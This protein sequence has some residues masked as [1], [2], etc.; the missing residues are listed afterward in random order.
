MFDYPGRYAQP[1]HGEHYARTRLEAFHARHEQAR[2]EG[3]ARGLSCGALFNLTDYPRADQNREYLIVAATYRL[4]SDAYLS[5]GSVLEGDAFHCTLTALDS[6]QPYR[7]PRKTRKPFVQGPQTAVVVGPPGEEIYTDRHGRVKVQFHWDREGQRNEN[8]SCWLRVSQ[9]WA[10]QGWGTVAIPRIGQEV[11]VDFLEGDPDQPLITGRVYNAQQRLPYPLPAA[12]H[13]MGFKSNSTPGGNGYCEMVIH[14]R[15]GEEK[16]V[17]HSQKDMSTTVRNNDTQHVMADRTIQ[18]DGHHTETIRKDLQLIVTEGNQSNVVQ[19]G[20]LYLEAAESITLKV[21]NSTLQMDKDG[22]ISVNGV[23]V[24]IVGSDR[25]DLNVDEAA[26]TGSDLL[27]VLGGEAASIAENL[28]EQL[29]SLVNDPVQHLA[30][31]LDRQFE[32][33]DRVAK[34]DREATDELISAMLPAGGLAGTVKNVT[35]NAI[36]IGESQLGKKLGKHVRDFGGNPANAA[37][38]Q[39]VIDRISDIANN[40][41]RV[42]PGT[43][44]GQGA[45]GD[46]GPVNFMIQ[47]RD[48]L[49]ATPEGK[50]VTI[51]KDGINK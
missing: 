18:V 19:S 35:K 34:G 43:F 27:G 30:N 26:G 39:R 31:N 2:A 22:H 47:G 11:I 13:M 32:V 12:A 49:V 25:V 41:D 20:H 14:D 21:G 4:Q 50:F 37:D 46:R 45:N 15:A 8:S 40:P 24:R 42:V 1:E 44:R 10:G 16:I 23:Y 29:R 51:L 33:L 36:S 28:S 6:R 38:R 48:V 17:L 3:N 9:P 7:P 5:G